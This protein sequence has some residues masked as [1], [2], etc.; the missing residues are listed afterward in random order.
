MQLRSFDFFFHFI[1][2]TT[3][4][5]T[6]E[7]AELRER[8]LDTDGGSFLQHLAEHEDDRDD[9]ASQVA[10]RGEAG[11]QCEHDI[12]VHVKLRGGE[13]GGTDGTDHAEHDGQRHDE[14]ADESEQRRDGG[15]AGP[16]PAGEC[17][18][19]EQAGGGE[20]QPQARTRGVVEIV[21]HREKLGEGSTRMDGAEFS[22]GRS[23]RE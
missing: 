11:G 15:L 8:H 23:V 3:G 6:V 12:L 9:A 19:G 18:G 22:A 21:S 20:E 7:L 1:T 2:P 13:A 16:Q 4:G 14:H 17:G 10:A 5:E